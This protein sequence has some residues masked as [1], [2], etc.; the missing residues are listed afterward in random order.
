MINIFR[1]IGAGQ[2]TPREPRLL[3]AAGDEGNQ[4]PVISTRPNQ[5]NKADKGHAEQRHGEDARDNSFQSPLR[6]N[7]VGQSCD[8]GIETAMVLQAILSSHFS[9]TVPKSKSTPPTVLA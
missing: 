6:N 5:A 7:S 3:R 9:S 1:S 4:N 2:L 8:L